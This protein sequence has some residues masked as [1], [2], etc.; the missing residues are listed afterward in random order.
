VANGYCAAHQAAKNDHKRLYDRY[1]ADD[2]V[3]ALYRCKRWRSVRMYV[4]RRDVLCVAC[5]HQAAT[6]ADHILSARLILDN[7]GID[8]FYDASRIQGLC[9]NCHCKKTALE[10]GWTGKKGT[11]ITD[12][13]DRTNTTVVCGQAGSGK[14]T[15]VANHRSPN[16]HVWDYDY[17]MAN[18]TGLP[19][20]QSL[21]GAVGSVLADRDRWIEATR[22]SPHHCW[23]IVSNLKAHIVSMLQDAGASVV[24]MD[25]PDD[26][27]QQRLRE[28]FIAQ[29][30]STTQIESIS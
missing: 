24:V 2:P 13:G 10:S 6:E 9:H 21:P 16:D 20:H 26:V 4:L 17:V 12:V 5:G 1:R 15:Y 27:C 23:L 30:L 11:K 28:R 22:R 8:A 19:L 14:T 3:R 29:A 7:D 18:I 25:T